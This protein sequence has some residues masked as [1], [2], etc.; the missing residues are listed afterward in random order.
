MAKR[1]RIEKILTVSTIAFLLLL[2]FIVTELH[3]FSDVLVPSPYKVIKSFIE[4][5]RDG[6][7]E[8]S[9]LTHLGDSMLRLLGSFFLV[10]VTAV[11]LGL[12][13]GYNSRVAAVIEPIIEFY[14]PLPPLAYYTLL[15]LW[16]G[17]DN[18]SKIAL[19]YLAGFAPAYIACASG[20]KKI[21]TDYIDGAYTLGANSR[22]I[23]F[24]VIFPAC[25]P[26]I[27]I[28]LRTAMGV[29]YTTLVAAEMV[30]A[31]TGIGWMVLDASK[32]LRSDIIFL[33]IF[34]MGITG[35]LIDGVIRFFEHK[36]V[37]WKGKE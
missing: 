4:I 31:V 16:L 12:I 33:G 35:I 24:H 7:K 10:I 9:L 5:A 36:V 14:R 32:F 17:I 6:Y 22:Q 11:P 8:N 13:S 20:V 21:R 34:I 37:P 29:A 25:L 2:W 30:A 26:D 18:S 23:F 28:G 15:V 27:F 3:L 1:I 19:L